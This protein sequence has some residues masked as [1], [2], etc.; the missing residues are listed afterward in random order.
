MKSKKIR[1]IVA[2]IQK[3]IEKSAQESK[4]TSADEYAKRI[5][6]ATHK[7]AKLGYTAEEVAQIGKARW[8]IETIVQRDNRRNISV[9][10]T[11]CRAE[12]EADMHADK[13]QFPSKCKTCGHEID[14]DAVRKIYEE[15]LKRW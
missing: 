14:M 4:H 1:E 11:E 9:I 15:D 7:L 13:I 2:M 8:K 3:D 6:L 5:A 10:C 12:N